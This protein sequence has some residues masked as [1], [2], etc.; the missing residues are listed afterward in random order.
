M[1]MLRNIILTVFSA[2]GLILFGACKKFVQVNTPITSVATS[3]VYS[4]NATAISAVNS[5]YAKMSNGSFS[6][7]GILSISLYGGLSADELV[8][9]SGSSNQAFI[10][11]YTNA[12]TNLNVNSGAVDIWTTIYPLVYDANVVIEGLNS[13][14][15]VTPA[16][17]Q[18]LLGEAKFIRAFCYFYLT[19]F[20]GDVPLVLSSTYTTTALMGR[21]GQ[22]QVW[23][24][25]I[26][27]LK[28]A[29]SELSASYLDATLLK[30]STERVRPTK[31]AAQ[32]LLART[33][34]YTGDWA[35]AVDL[36]DSVIANSG[37]Y[38]LGS[39]SSAFLKNNNEAIWQLQP[40]LTGYNTQEAR[41]FVLPASGPGAA[42]PF[43]LD[44]FLVKA[45]EAND[46]R[47][48]NWI[49]SVTAGGKKYY[50]AY[51]YK[52]SATNQSVQEYE[53]VLRLGEQYLI[54]AEAEAQQGDL[55]DAVSDL[56]K[57]R[58]RAGL[59]GTTATT[60]AGILAAILH[61]RQ[62]ELFTEWGHRWLDLKRTNTVNTVMPMVTQAK[63]GTWNPN[64]QW[65]PIPLTDLTNDPNLVQNNG[66]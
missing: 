15:A 48:T 41:V 13:S 10:G 29:I 45:F 46:L 31:A 34:L 9:Y 55:T 56:N 43:F 4:G 65:Y 2:F 12:L 20:Y 63:G 22:S 27:D 11:Y 30:T 18:Q 24:Q 6:G 21:S 32:A 54:R 44:T 40:V 51:K 23:Q 8:L 33:Y 57:I 61:E 60:Q 66:Y 36:S 1:W 39:M 16:I 3:S 7:S 26:A 53:M 47:R 58:T 64:W 25:I 35:D 37:L 42:Y 50:Y 59:A 38:S 19:N 49:D 17:K 5:I 28:D 62:V 14:S 52:I